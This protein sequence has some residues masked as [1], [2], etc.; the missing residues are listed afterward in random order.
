MKRTF[1]EFA[2]VTQILRSVGVADEARRELERRIMQDEGDVIRG[3]RGLR[4][5]RCAA[6]GRGKS[7][8][9]RIVYADYPEIGQCLLIV[10]FA[11]NEKENLTPTER[12]E[13]AKLKA[14]LDKMMAQRV[15]PKR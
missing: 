12:N 2:K 10:A 14:A 5:I 3:T 13:L 1:V 15:L 9:V 6:T 7:G 4:K 8:G 11:K